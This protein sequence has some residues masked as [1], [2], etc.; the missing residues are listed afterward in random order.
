MLLVCAPG[1]YRSRDSNPPARWQSR[2]F[3]PFRGWLRCVIVLAS[4]ARAPRD[5]THP[6]CAA[7]LR[8]E[9]ERQPR[10]RRSRRAAA[11][12]PTP[13]QRSA[14]RDRAV[15]RRRG[16]GERHRAVPRIERSAALPLGA[17]PVGEAAPIVPHPQAL[18][19][20]ERRRIETWGGLARGV[21]VTPL[22]LR[23]VATA[24]TALHE[25]L[26]TTGKFGVAI[27]GTR[28]LAAALDR[29]RGRYQRVPDAK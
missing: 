21:A 24:V 22:F 29:Y 28:D 8:R 26:D 25:G 2:R 9:L 27:A 7:A 14:R 10:T 13:D 16:R 6:R 18:I 11:R 1:A 5:R 4:D 20:L 17:G 23:A 3:K 15:L 19:V 12:N